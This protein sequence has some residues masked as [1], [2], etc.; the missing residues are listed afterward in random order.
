MYQKAIIVALFVGIVAAGTLATALSVA[1]PVAK[2]TACAG[3]R[4]TKACPSE[5]K[6]LC[7][8]RLEEGKKVTE[9][10]G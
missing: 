10:T 7:V 2:A 6:R 3:E 5:P 9:C 1:A 4:D 8:I